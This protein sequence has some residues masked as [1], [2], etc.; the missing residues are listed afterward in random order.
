VL[1]KKN[2]ETV[3]KCKEHKYTSDSIEKKARLVR[4]AYR[5]LDIVIRVLLRKLIQRLVQRVHNTVRTIRVVAGREA[6][7]F[8]PLA[9]VAFVDLGIVVLED[10]KR[11]GS[12]DVT[13]RE[14]T[15]DYAEL[16]GNGDLREAEAGVAEAGADAVRA[17]GRANGKHLVLSDTR[18]GLIKEDFRRTFNN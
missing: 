8:R 18:E 1:N 15:S 2:K 13:E 17:D 16:G 11:G 3:R 4:S 12:G 10:R 14:G 9:V 5:V 6:V 7:D